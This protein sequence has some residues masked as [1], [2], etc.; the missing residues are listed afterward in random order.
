MSDVGPGGVEQRQQEALETLRQKVAARDVVGALEALHASGTFEALA[1]YVRA[2][3]GSAFRNEGDIHHI[4]ALAVDALCEAIDAA[5]ADK[6]AAELR[7]LDLAEQVE[8]LG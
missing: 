7:W 6:D 4:V 1:R 8:S 5:R 3:W 2:N